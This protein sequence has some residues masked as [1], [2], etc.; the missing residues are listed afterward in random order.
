MDLATLFVR[1][2]ADTSDVDKSVKTLESNTTKSAGNIAK[3]LAGAFGGVV[4]G[5][6]IKKSIDAA[7][8]LQQAVGATQTV[9]GKA[10]GAVDDFAKHSADGFGISQTSARNLTAVIGALLQ[11]VGFTQAASA[12]LS[13]QLSKTGADLAAAFS[14]SPETAVAALSSALK[15]EFDPLQQYG[16][17]LTQAKVN[18]E[19]LKEGLVD[20]SGQ[21]DAHGKAVATLALIQQ[22]GALTSGAYTAQI[23]TA[24]EAQQRAKA[25]A[26][27]AAAALGQNLLPIYTKVVTVVGDLAAVFGSLPGPV[28]VATIALIGL[29]AVAGPISSLVQLVP[30]LAA[31][32]EALAG[33]N[34][35]ILAVAGLAI[36]AGAVVAA[37]DLFGNGADEAAKRAKEFYAEIKT[38]V[39]TVDAQKVALLDAAEAA[40]TYSDATYSD[41]DKKLRDT[42]VGNKQYV[43]AL[44]QLGL[45]LDDVTKVNRG[46]TEAQDVLTEARARGLAVAKDL[47]GNMSLESTALD[48]NARAALN[49]NTAHHEASVT[50]LHQVDVINDLINT[51]SN[52][53]QA[54]YDSA[55]SAANLAKIGDQQAYIYLKTTGQL[56]LLTAAEQAKAE[57]SLDS[58]EAAD[59]ATASATS[60]AAAIND[61]GLQVDGYGTITAGVAISTAS[62]AEATGKFTE[63][64]HAHDTALDAAKVATADLEVAQAQAKARADASATATSKLSDALD[65]TKGSES[66]AARAADLLDAALKRVFGGSLDLEDANRNLQAG[67]DAVAKSIKDNGNTLDIHTEKGRNNRQAIE[68]QVKT[69]QDKIKAD[70]ASGVSIE[71]ATAAGEAYRQTLIDTS[72]TTDDA[73]AAAEDYINQLGL[74]P[75]NISTAVQL[76]NDEQTK[77]KLK[78]MLTQLGTID[79]GAAAEIT[80]EIEQGKFDKAEADLERIAR[81]RQINLVVNV[82]GGGEIRLSSGAGGRVIVQSARGRYV[83]AGSNILTSAGEPGS[84]DEVI[85][86]LD[87]PQRIREL[88]GSNNV[89][90]RILAALS[91]HQQPAGGAVAA[92]TAL[93]PT[94]T[95]T[96]TVGL[97]VDH[98]EIHDDTSAQA[99]AQIVMFKMAGV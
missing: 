82:T 39:A 47:T 67:I 55:Q 93:A 45:T 76:T 35:A 62:A 74:T 69:I 51:L 1:F 70:I 38:G 21:V 20:A 14:G 59:K 49:N 88:A 41:A 13:V 15:G 43:A 30:K 18:A 44:Q 80:A 10:S 84:G 4:I 25:K 79:A 31:G 65:D 97:H 56:N 9:F 75:E 54:S 3:A 53:T 78:D 96:S 5:A 87:D 66:A 61:L 85:F 6:A 33:L 17:T 7:T 40:K 26:D 68:D 72:G 29:V 73:R 60:Q 92:S 32:L 52:Q 8:G 2:K 98:L 71:A 77:A 48:Y 91:D 42:I 63:I 99:L 28:Q 36:A 86:P 27:D 83:V 37:L 58:A 94:S 11:G 57:A 89:G 46:G 81:D 22:Q 64:L 95:S 90:S 12:D 34:P 19:A 50:A 16:I 23:D 24:A